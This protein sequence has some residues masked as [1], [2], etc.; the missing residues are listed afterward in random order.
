MNYVNILS[1]IYYDPHYKLMIGDWF[2]PP[3]EA[4]RI[5]IS[6]L[7]EFGF[8]RWFVGKLV[9]F[10]KQNAQMYKKH[11]IMWSSDISDFVS[12]T[13]RHNYKWCYDKALLFPFLY[14]EDVDNTQEWDSK[15]LSE[16]FTYWEEYCKI[17]KLNNSIIKGKT[18]EYT[19]YRGRTWKEILGECDYPVLQ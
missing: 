9:K 4:F 19:D 10:Y 17:K 5:Y 8:Y 1:R 15:E 14:M 16:I 6:F 13:K 11:F 12:K 18:D 7:K 3:E 2:L